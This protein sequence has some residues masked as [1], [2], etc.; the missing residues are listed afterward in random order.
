MFRYNLKIA[1]RAFLK[2]KGYSFINVTGLA[3]GLTACLLILL[4]VQDELT[5]DKFHEKADRIYIV[6]LDIKLGATDMKAAA[7]PPPMMFALTE[8]FTG[9]E[10]SSRYQGGQAIVKY[11]DK[12]FSEDRFAFVDSTFFEIFTFPFITGDPNTALDRPN[13]VVITSEMKIKY[14]G[15]EDPVGKILT[16]NGGEDYEITGVCETPPSQ[17]SIDFDF[18]ASMTARGRPDANQWGSNSLQT[19]ILVEQ[20]VT[21]AEIDDQFPA[22]LDKYFGPIINAIMNISLDEFYE[23]G[24]RYY[25][26]LESLTD[27]HLH[28]SF[29]EGI[30]SSTDTIYVYVLSIIA[31]FILFIACINFVNLT[32]ARS[33]LRAKEVGLKK[34]VGS[35]RG[36][37]INQ[38]LTESM[39]I[40]IISMILAVVLVEVLLGKFNN[41]A[42]KELS[43]NYFSNPIIIP[44]LLILTI[45]VGFV[46]GS[47]AAFFQ[48]SVSIL[49]VLKGKF[50]HAMK[51]GVLR[52][53][54]VIFQFTISIFLII[55]TLTVFMQIRYI[56]NMDVGF[57]KD[58]ILV[59]DRFNSVDDQQQVFKAELLK[60]PMIDNASISFNVPGTGGFSG[61]GILKEGGKD[62]EV[63]ILSRWWADFDLLETMGFTIA[64]GRYYS[65]EFPTDS[66]AI[67]I[68]QVSIHA[69]ELDDPLNQRLIEPS[70][71][72]R[73]R[74]IIGIVK[75][76]NFQTA[77]NPIRP[78][79]LEILRRDQIGRF[80]LIHV[81][82]GN[83]QSVIRKAEDLWMEMVT[84]QPFEYF[85]LDEE[86]DEAYQGERRLGIIYSIFSILAV[87]I[88]CL[89]LF[90]MASFTTEQ[91][92][93]D[94]GI[95]KAMGATATSIV[96]LL[97]KEFN[98][99]VL[100]ANIVAWPLAFFLMKNWLENFAF[101]IDQG[102][103]RYI[104]AALITLVIAVITVSYQSIRA[105]IRNPADSLR[106]E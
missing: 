1:L 81:Q 9:I 99:W 15:N 64:E 13:T 49:S 14:F 67:I 41:L 35:S 70:D 86:F 89:G 93:K 106:Y 92:T 85:F 56:R 82:R 62:S 21:R 74:S 36:R 2:Q 65:E 68:N 100:A 94:I 46:A 57:D 28:S 80:L 38:F 4:W 11:E 37:L 53:V 40:S 97:T 6:G 101:R 27:V 5:Y 87:F 29:T 39:I 3:I 73:P 58:Q 78:L 52:N 31:L 34:V 43:V 60:D 30:E 25:Y 75:D 10:Q 7:T 48:S 50:T 23:G 104:L 59:I 77:H 72:V 47:Y 90:G 26:Y 22:L 66:N 102:I 71:S 91:K 12:I 61:N 84:D 55:C 95:R 96:F 8:E 63:H 44:S 19:F 83:I 20:G 16:I 98:K 105:A 103:W 45:F 17:S 79:S 88:A 33:S 18:L 24:N 32:T 76:F 69:M 51:T 54:L 42:E